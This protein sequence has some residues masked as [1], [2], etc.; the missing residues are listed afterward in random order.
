MLVKN[1]DESNL[2]E[3]CLIHQKSFGDAHFTSVFPWEL[4]KKYYKEII[5][6]CKYK[7]VVYE[8]VEKK[9]IG[10]A[11]GSDNISGL[12]SSFIKDNFLTLLLLLIKHPKFLIEKIRGFI[13]SL[14]SREKFN[15]EAKVMLL[16][17][18]VNPVI[19][20]KGKGEIVL[21][22]FEN[23]LKFNGITLYNLGV[24]KNNARA[25]RFYEKTGFK[26]EFSG[27]IEYYFIKTLK[28]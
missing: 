15:S 12:L 27:S 3:I 23:I 7:V 19:N 2:D 13:F 4:L 1:I 28:I 18:A 10:F 22:E 8:P 14:V 5:A 25:I 16:S 24:R 6:V 9:P 21:S 26:K 20:M 17:I 11:I